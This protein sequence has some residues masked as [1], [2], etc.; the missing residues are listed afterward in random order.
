MCQFSSAAT[1]YQVDWSGAAYRPTAGKSCVL[2]SV[3]DDCN[4]RV[5]IANTSLHV[6]FESNAPKNGYHRDYNTFCPF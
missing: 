6:L 1:Q 4:I 2:Y 5:I 3:H